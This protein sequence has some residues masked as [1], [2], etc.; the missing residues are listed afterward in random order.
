MPWSLLMEYKFSFL[1]PSNFWI[2]HKRFCKPRQTPLKLKMFPRGNMQNW[3]FV[4]HKPLIL[5]LRNAFIFGKNEDAHVFVYNSS[6]MRNSFQQLPAVE[7]AL[8]YKKYY[9]IWKS[10]WKI[11]AWNYY[12][13]RHDEKLIDSGSQGFMNFHIHFV[14]FRMILAGS[15]LVQ[16][17]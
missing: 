2:E 6:K 8:W 5:R 7:D 15:I 17:L 1:P 4:L 13:V 12:G 3:Y 16:I 14:Y 10:K 9:V 11:Y